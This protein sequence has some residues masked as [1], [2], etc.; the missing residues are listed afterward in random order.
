MAAHAH[1]DHHGHDHPHDESHGGHAH[2][3]HH[4]ASLTWALVFTLGFAIVEVV[5]GLLSGSLALLSDA[6]HMVSDV[7]ALALAAFAQRLAVRPPSSRH[8]YGFGRAEVVAALINGLLMLMVIVWIAVEAV[9]RLLAPHPVAGGTVMVVAGLGLLVNVIVAF[10]LSRDAHSLNT[11]AAL[12]HV[13]G[14][15]LGSVAALLAGAVIQFTGWMPIDP[16]LSVLVAGL[17]LFSTVSLI[18]HALQVL[19]EGVPA[20]LDFEAIGKAIAVIP[21]VQSAHD[22]HVWSLSSGKVALSAHLTLNSLEQWP[23]IL[24]QARLML[25]QRFAIEH[26]TLQP[27]PADLGQRYQ[28][29]IPIVARD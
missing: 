6:G 26:V 19:M 24:P 16:I 9:Q 3:H 13:M 14:D 27:E 17:I 29:Q 28:V 4:G 10:V 1:H 11:R 21:G 12:L 23:R 7:V 22:L 15:L 2:A 20:D 8:S 25:K 18:R 5:G